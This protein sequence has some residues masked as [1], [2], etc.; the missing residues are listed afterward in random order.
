MVSQ[1]VNSFALSPVG[2][3]KLHSSTYTLVTI[4]V[5]VSGSMQ[6]QERNVEKFLTLMSETC[7]SVQDNVLIEVLAF[8][9][10]TDHVVQWNPLSKILE[11]PTLF[12][13]TLT[14]N[15]YTDIYRCLE[16]A[17]TSIMR[18]GKEL[19]ENEYS[20]NSLLVLVTD[21]GQTQ[22][23]GF[24]THQQAEMLAA[25]IS[26]VE[27]AYGESYRGI[28]IEVGSEM[29]EL[30]KIANG[31]RFDQREQLANADVTSMRKLANFVSQS[32]RAQSAAVGTGGP[33]QAIDFG[34]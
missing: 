6:G 11:A 24:C 34:I 9:T 18:K 21:G 32:I 8:N 12:D 7:K 3:E 19:K 25:E 1:Q 4:C 2:V 30:D 31:C 28:L 17:F 27:S 15:G 16:T 22:G 20:V 29:K 33:S 26:Q 5:D 23:P 14:A 10:A 13:N